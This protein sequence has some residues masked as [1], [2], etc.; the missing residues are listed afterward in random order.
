M[1][2]R[3]PACVRSSAPTV[4]CAGESVATCETGISIVP[5]LVIAAEEPFEGRF[6][7]HMKTD[8]AAMT[9]TTPTAAAII[10]GIIVGESVF[11]SSSSIVELSLG[12]PVVTD[13]AETEAIADVTPAALASLAMV[14]SSAPLDCAELMVLPT[15]VSMLSGLKASSS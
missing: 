13:V 14:L 3:F 7:Y 11:S 2:P 5:C 6:R 12:E 1:R 10:I 8:P 9:T 15:V 4:P